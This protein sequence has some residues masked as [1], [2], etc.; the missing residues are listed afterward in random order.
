MMARSSKLLSHDEKI[1][2]EF[3]RSLDLTYFTCS[4]CSVNFITRQLGR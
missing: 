4:T 1:S 2:S 3:A